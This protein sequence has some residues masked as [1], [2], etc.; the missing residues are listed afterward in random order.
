[1]RKIGGKDIA[2]LVPS[3][4]ALGLLQPLLVRPN[5]AGFDIIA[6]QRRYYALVALADE[7]HID[8]VPFMIMGDGD[9]APWGIH[10]PEP[11]QQERT[12][13]RRG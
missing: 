1:M 3:I 11:M 9:D 7:Q 4:R 12:K 2:D 5:D 8:P 10:P 6:E 13:P